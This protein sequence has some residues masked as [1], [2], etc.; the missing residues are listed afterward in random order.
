MTCPTC[1]SKLEVADEDIGHTVQC[2]S[3]QQTFTAEDPGRKR[4]DGAAR[5]PDEDDRRPSS[6]RGS[7]GGRGRDDEDD[8]PTRRRDRD[9]DDDEDDRPS[10]RRDRDD[11]DPDDDYRPRRSR[12]RD[13]DEAYERRYGP[14]QQTG[15]GITSMILGILSIP[16]IFCYG[17]GIILGILAIIF[18]ILSLKTAGRGMGIA[19]IIT[20][21]IAFLLFGGL[22]LLYVFAAAAR[23]GGN[24]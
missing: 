18:G 1:G 17:F 23:G 7:G 22:I 2:G 9:R 20:A 11:E 12:F 24:F 19:G 10:R 14:A 6:R 8:R 5:D 15:M 4:N 16:T 13:D 3:C 21:V